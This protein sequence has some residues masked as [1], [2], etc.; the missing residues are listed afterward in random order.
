M[1]NNFIWQI[2]GLSRLNGLLSVALWR[3][4]GRGPVDLDNIAKALHCQPQAAQKKTG[5]L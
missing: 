3:V 4:A 5:P 1:S 2:K